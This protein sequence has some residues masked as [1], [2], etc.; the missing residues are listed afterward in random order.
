MFGFKQN[1]YFS[2]NTIFIAKRKTQP[3]SCGC[4]LPPNFRNTLNVQNHIVVGN[5]NKQVTR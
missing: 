1:C 5:T 2:L 4:F 3:I